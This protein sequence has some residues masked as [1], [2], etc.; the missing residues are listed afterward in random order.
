[1]T[2]HCEFTLAE[3]MIVAASEAFRGD[4]EILASGLGIIPPSGCQPG[5][6]DPYP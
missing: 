4:G 5:E 6:D 3:L 2:T 1:M